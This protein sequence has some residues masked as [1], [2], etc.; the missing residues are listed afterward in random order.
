MTHNIKP[1]SGRIGALTYIESCKKWRARMMVNRV[2]KH[3][4]MYD[5]KEQAQQAIDNLLFDIANG[6]YSDPNEIRK[7][8][9]R[10]KAEQEAQQRAEKEEARY[11]K[12]VK[13]LRPSD[14]D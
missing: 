14:F 9:R 6:Q 5:T 3:I 12:W 8:Q 10:I 2:Y 4:G 13:S 11:Q 7:N 1:H